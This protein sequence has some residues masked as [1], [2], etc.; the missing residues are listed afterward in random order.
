VRAAIVGVVGFAF[1]LAGT[2]LVLVSDRALVAIA[3]AAQRLR[4]AIL[5]RR[6]PLR[7]LPGRLVVQRDAMIRTLGDRW[8]LALT[9]ACGRTLLDFLALLCALSAVGTSPR[10]GLVLLAYVAATLLGMI[11]ITPGGLGFVEAGLTSTLVL[12]GVGGA[13]AVLATLAYRLASYWLPLVA[14]AAAYGG[15]RVGFR[16]SAAQ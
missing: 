7:D 4:N 14:G 5:R 6:E 12:A 16:G 11:P 15:Y 8:W 3:R 2:T 10:P 9:A 1:V 13:D